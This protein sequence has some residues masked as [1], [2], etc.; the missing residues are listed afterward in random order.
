MRVRLKLTLSTLAGE[1]RIRFRGRR[2]VSPSRLHHCHASSSDARQQRA[3]L[4]QVSLGLRS[5]DTMAM[6]R[7]MACRWIV[8]QR[9][10][11]LTPR[12]PHWHTWQ[13][14]QTEA[15]RTNSRPIMTSRKALGMPCP[16]GPHACSTREPG[17]SAVTVGRNPPKTG[18]TPRNVGS[19]KHPARRRNVQPSPSGRQ[20]RRYKRACK[21]ALARGRTRMCLLAARLKL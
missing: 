19:G 6:S 7:V 14:L 15:D 10:L 17:V 9:V 5:A 13:I 20:R 11:K 16:V 18:R 4:S 12:A 3:A 8:Q 2:A 1:L 21:E